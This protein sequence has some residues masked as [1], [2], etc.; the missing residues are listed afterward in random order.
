MTEATVQRRSAPRRQ[1]IP[2]NA[3]L[4]ASDYGDSLLYLIR[5]CAS[6]APGFPQVHR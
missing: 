4:V 1:L 2:M 3:S 6:A 5:G